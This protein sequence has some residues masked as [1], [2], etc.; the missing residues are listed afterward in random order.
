MKRFFQQYTG[1]KQRKASLRHKWT[2]SF[3]VILVLP[4]VINY[5]FYL[6]QTNNIKEELDAKNVSYYESVVREMDLRIQKYK[7]I[8][9]DL[10]INTL[11]RQVSNL[12]DSTAFSPE[13]KSDLKDTLY[14]YYIDL[15]N[16]YRVFL[17]FDESNMILSMNETDTA[18]AYLKNNLENDESVIAQWKRW[19][20]ESGNE[21]LSFQGPP[22]IK[23]IQPRYIAL[24]YTIFENRNVHPTNIVIILDEASILQS[25]QNF[26]KDDTICL[27][28]LSESGALIASSVTADI[29]RD[30]IFTQ[31]KGKS[32]NFEITEQNE[33]YN[34]WHLMSDINAWQYVFYV[35]K[36]IYYSKVT[37]SN[38]VF[39]GSILLILIVGLI[40]IREI[41]GKQYAPI[42]KILGKMPR[43][44]VDGNE[45]LEIENMI[46]SSIKINRENAS[47][48]E[49]QERQ[50]TNHLLYMA[51]N[52]QISLSEINEELSHKLPLNF[53]TGY[54]AVAIFSLKPY[55]EL[56][57]EEGHF[58]F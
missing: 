15:Y 21:T 19:L 12:P 33:K 9:A 16:T 1:L 52:G 2:R 8:S 57:R 6:F 4:M 42:A 36:S 26:L 43:K 51:L 49:R 41:V 27:D 22:N 50:H 30:K 55:K 45:Y 54:N 38:L 48:A 14:R 28:I 47:I 32:G 5:G 23:G 24:R 46:L 56:F 40:L 31:L 39:L 35:S 13:L 29:N 34:V 18:E 44:N 10:G 17:Y 11:I 20:S 53:E 25:I 3:I 58:R 37:L 7:K